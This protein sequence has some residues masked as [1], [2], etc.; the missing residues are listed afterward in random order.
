MELQ[1]YIDELR[2]L[3]DIDCGTTT[4]DGVAHVAGLMRQKYLDMGWHAELVDL[5]P[6]VGPGVLAT[7]KP[8]AEHYDVLLVG[9]LDTVFPVGTVAERP[10][11]I[12]GNIARGPGAADMKA[13]LLNIA[14]ALRGLDPET[15]DRLA[16][17]V[18]MNPDEETGSVHSHDWI[19]RYAQKSRCVLVAEAARTDGT[20]VKARKGV[21]MYQIDFKGVA[22][23]A[24]N[25]HEKGRS[26][27]TELAHWTLALNT[28][29]DYA[30][31]TTV[32][33]G[34]ISGGTASNVVPE[35]ASATIDIR[36]WKT[37][38][39][40]KIERA[41][42]DLQAQPFTP[43]V[44]ITLKR[45]SVMPAMEASAKTEALM[46]TVE[47]AGAEMGL[48]IGWKAVGGGSD[49]NHTAALGIPSLDG[50]GPIGGN[51]HNENEYLELDSVLPR[52][53]LLQNVLRRL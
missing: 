37:S 48:T 52:I 42:H 35:H 30:A 4:L 13:G 25:D 10:L 33:V 29:T 24:G 16:I 26:A 21:G 36:F 28:L 47:A 46:Q 11:S 31:G 50:L 19:G 32:N 7:N 8:G 6:A 23:H 20:L 15:L 41:L 40:E 39:F 34:Q 3:V 12:D 5:G 1:L 45:L 53:Q 43:D 44:S 18:A 22:A 49:A 51:F 38:E 2:P 9:H 27:V 14:W 17:C